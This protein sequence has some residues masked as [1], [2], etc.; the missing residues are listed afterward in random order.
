MSEYD[1]WWREGYEVGQASS[2][3]PPHE[4]LRNHGAEIAQALLEAAQAL[5][6]AAQDEG[7][8]MVEVPCPECGYKIRTLRGGLTYRSLKQREG[9]YD[10]ICNCPKEGRS[11]E[12]D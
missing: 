9:A 7:E 5:L 6:E 1:W 11:E 12:H 3:G 10:W 2:T 4:A 8:G